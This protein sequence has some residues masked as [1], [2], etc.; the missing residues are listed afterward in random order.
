MTK[1][2]IHPEAEV[3]NGVTI[4][5]YCHREL[6]NGMAEQPF[7]C[8]ISYDVPFDV[9][10]AISVWDCSVRVTV[11]GID[12]IAQL[13]LTA[14][15]IKRLKR[16][17]VKDVEAV[18]GAI[19]FSGKYPPSDSTVKY[20]MKLYEKYEKFALKLKLLEA[21]KEI[22]SLEDSLR[23]EQEKVWNL[24]H[25]VQRYFKASDRDRAWLKAL[26][27]NNILGTI[28]TSDQEVQAKIEAVKI[29]FPEYYRDGVLTEDARTLRAGYVAVE[30]DGLMF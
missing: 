20:A 14:P 26:D 30:H 9:D 5:R 3:I 28:Y 25:A 4:C 1:Y 19:N 29:S 13:P 10:V 7:P 18:G 12:L 21:E 23:Y 16:L 17:A 6:P 27:E 24:K 22:S 15:E 11:N 8:T 2:Y